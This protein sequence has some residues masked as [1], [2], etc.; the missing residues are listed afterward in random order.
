MVDLGWCS[1]SMIVSQSVDP[2]VSRSGPDT[3]GAGA[4]ASLD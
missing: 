3:V 4:A 1:R 2:E